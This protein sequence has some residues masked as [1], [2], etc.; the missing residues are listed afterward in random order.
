[1]S[2]GDVNAVLVHGAWTDGSSWSAV[3]ARLKDQGINAIAASLP[4]S[5][6]S[7]DVVALERTLERINGPVV[8]VGH[9]Y[10]GA[11][12]GSIRSGNVKALV[13][14]AA[15]APDEGEMASDVFNLG[16]SHQWMPELVPDRHGLIWLSQEAFGQAFAQHATQ[17]ELTVLAAAQRPISASCMDEAVERAVWKDIPSW[18]L[19]AEQDRMISPETQHFMARRMNAHVR[20]YRA[21]HMAIVTAPDDVAHVIVEAFLSVCGQ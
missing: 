14:V 1:M 20:S 4:L 3:I 18:F 6:L 10:A 19:I 15:L 2:S 8:V 16:G 7:Y 17:R 11:V 9:G 13:Y 5:S 12:I 21:D